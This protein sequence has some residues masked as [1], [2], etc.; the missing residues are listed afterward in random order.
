MTILIP[1]VH[2][3]GNEPTKI[4][5]AMKKTI[6][7]L[8]MVVLAFV[9][10]MTIGC[11]DML[12]V[13]TGGSADGREVILT[14]TISF[15]GNG[16]A[17]T[18]AL[19]A[20]GHKTFAEGDQIAVIYKNTS[21][22]TVKAVSIALTPED[23][24]SDGKKARI[25]VTLT[26][27]A[28]G[29]RVRYI[30][31]AVMAKD[32][33]DIKKDRSV[34]NDGN[35]IND[36]R[37]NTQDGTLASLEAGLDLAVYDGYLTGTATLPDN[38]SLT[39]KLGICKLTIMNG[40]T[41]VTSTITSMTI[42]HESYTYN[43]TP[44]GAT[45]GAG[46]IY[47]ALREVPGFTSLYFSAT[48]AET[49]YFKS[50]RNMWDKIIEKGKMYPVNLKMG[51]QVGGNVN[52]STVTT[53]L[54]LLDGATVSGTLSSNVKISIDD[55][56]TVTLNGVTIN[57]VNDSNYKW[58]GLTCVGDATIILADGS[59]NNVKGFEGDHPGIHAPENSDK[60]LTIK[61]G[62]LGTGVLN[63]SS[64]NIAPAIGSDWSAG[65]GNI[66]IEGGHITAVGGCTGIGCGA[67]NC[68]S[69]IITGGNI[70]ATGQC[71]IGVGQNGS[72][73]IIT[74]TGGKITATGTGGAGIGTCYSGKF[75]YIT[76]RGG[77]ITATGGDYSSGIGIGASGG[78]L[79]GG[80]GAEIT[81]SGGKIVAIGGK[82]ASGIGGGQFG[83]YISLVINNDDGLLGVKATR[84]SEDAE[85]IGKGKEDYESGDVTI[86]VGDGFTDVTS[87]D[88]NTRTISTPYFAAQVGDLFYS[89]GTYSSTLEP[90]KTPI[91]VI[92]YLAPTDIDDDE[93]TEK[94]Y[95]YGH[96][97]VL[98]LKNAATGVDWST[99]NN[100][101]LFEF[102][103]SAK[104]ESNVGL[105]RLTA[106]SGY[107]NHWTLYDKYGFETN[108]PAAAA[109]YQ[110]MAH[111]S[112]TSYWFL[113]S[114]QQW[115][116]MLEAL[117]GLSRS[118]IV[119]GEW[120]DHN[121]LAATAIENALKKAGTGNYDSVTDGLKWYWTSSEYTKK[122]V[123]ILG[124]K[125][126]D[127]GSTYS[128]YWNHSDKVNSF[129]TCT[130]R[131]VL[132]F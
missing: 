110:Y 76:I 105:W 77:D 5:Q 93:I 36:A 56:A 127:T 71:G 44:S 101:D 21:N 17:E 6:K 66:R 7:Y 60:T 116:K 67:D 100:N 57:G 46:P 129:Y 69:I 65:C 20:T 55:G 85:P 19:D 11:T 3:L 87:N 16:D 92:A 97:L 54:L 38:P 59:T 112:S 88:G 30:Y 4:M 111:P 10:A 23:I 37:L 107:D 96:G 86:N 40:N 15:D 51:L 80:N 14:T 26:N 130:V 90:G 121:H 119:W 84:G 27:P 79:D 103:E 43:I 89:D 41:D 25:T 125:A 91:G 34:N 52:L 104:V 99:E 75:G 81:I 82:D 49:S 13:P 102:G 73:N 94:D 2:I 68:N 61:G 128:L 106:A 123:V 83:R 1:I 22:E 58:G 9:G 74:I 109:A 108:Y 120:F 42:K 98:S 64:N 62:A 124:I 48:S 8:T 31:P 122:W 18:R 50:I 28:A 126:M 12:D 47:V 132:A 95:G 45:F 32:E 63:V 117:G 29:G 78:P 131:P 72:C 113:P 53:D 114:A 70:T 24:S 118:E 115:V 35:T 33:S 39:N